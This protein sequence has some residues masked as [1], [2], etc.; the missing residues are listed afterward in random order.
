MEYQSKRLAGQNVEINSKSITI[1]KTSLKLSEISK[2]SSKR[3]TW[4]ALLFLLAAVTSFQIGL[5]IWGR[6][7]LGPIEK[8]V[9]AFFI[10]AAFAAAFKGVATTRA[11]PHRLV[12]V[13]KGGE[14]ISFSGVAQM[15][16][17]MI[18]QAFTASS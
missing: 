3:D 12:I 13:T 11:M 4:S 17:Q 10:L 7:S 9:I 15:D 5:A 18:E 6:E 14:E 2:L 8:A 1:G 16:V